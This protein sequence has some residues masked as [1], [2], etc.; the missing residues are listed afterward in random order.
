MQAVD[1][2]SALADLVA[3]VTVSRIGRVALT[4]AESVIEMPNT[5][6]LVTSE[7]TYILLRYDQG[8][9]TCVS[10][11]DLKALW[12]SGDHEPGEWLEVA[13]MPEGPPSSA[14]P[15]TITHVSAQVGIG[16]CQDV[17][18]LTLRTSTG[19]E[20]VLS[21]GHDGL[22][23]VTAEEI[24]R[25]AEEVAQWAKMRIEQVSITPGW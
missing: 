13:A 1:V 17:L 16:E 14:L 2:V 15:A 9:L 23:V 10:G 25:V 8:G 5:L 11:P 3:S 22:E 21:T 4:T 19:A 7:G 18:G 20:L 24:L 12:P 6:V